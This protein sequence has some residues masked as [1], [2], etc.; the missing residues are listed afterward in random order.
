MCEHD[1]VPDDAFGLRGDGG[2]PQAERLGAKVCFGGG[3]RL[4]FETPSE[5]CGPGGGRGGAAGWT[6][7]YCGSSPGSSTSRVGYSMTVL[8]ARACRRVLAWSKRKYRVR[9]PAGHQMHLA[10]MSVTFQ[11]NANRLSYALHVD[12]ACPP[13]TG[14]CSRRMRT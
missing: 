5:G 10:R 7:G 3:V 1:A 14:L 2:A 11:R 13:R 6:T 9:S 4:K 12:L 8:P